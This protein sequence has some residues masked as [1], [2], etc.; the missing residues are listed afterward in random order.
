MALT[1][2]GPGAGAD[3]ARRRPRRPVG[4]L[5]ALIL[6][7]GAAFVVLRLV[8]PGDGT[9]VPP[10]TWAWTGDGVLVQAAP[11]STLRNRDLVTAVDG[12]ALGGADGT[13]WAPAHRPGDRLVYQ[14]VRGGQTREVPVTLRRAELVDRLRQAWGT[15]LFVVALFVVVAYL[16]ARRPGPATGGLLVLGS[17]LLSSDLAIELGVSA[18]DAR[19]DPVLW[20]YVVNTQVVYVM[21]WAGLVAFVVLF[22]RPWPPLTRHRWLLSVVCV[23]PVALVAGL[24]LAALGGVGLTQW[25]GRVIAGETFVSVAARGMGIVV[26]MVRYLTAT[27]P[28]GRQQLKWLAGGAVVSG[29]LALMVWFLPQLLF[30][31]GLLPAEWLGFSGLP[32][33]AGLTV[34]VLRYPLFDVD[35]IISRTLA[36][37][38]LTLLLGGG[39]AAVVL[40]L[41]QLLGHD[42]SLVVAAA[43]LAAAALFQPAR[44][45]IQAL[46]D[47]RLNRRHYDTTQTVAAFSARLPEQLDLDTL[48]AELLTVAEQ[49]MQPASASLWL[50]P[51]ADRTRPP[52]AGDGTSSPRDVIR[53]GAGTAGGQA[54]G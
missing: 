5:V 3:L 29:T 41:G 28:I 33:V 22:P 19:G 39:Y 23:T 12:V 49:T 27:D 32:L 46:V 16:Y 35:R 31:E 17:G 45:R 52:S 26:A 25:V 43:T 4:W 44:R 47:R 24:A 54:G 48:S 30:G 38:L 18:A 21:G 40:G 13:W 15:I 42:S 7:A 36:Y 9:Q 8:T 11:D 10:R 34:A 6:A 51:P 20:L 53:N 2:A 1:P 50:R 37:A 14:V